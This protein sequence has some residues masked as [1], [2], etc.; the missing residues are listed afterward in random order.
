MLRQGYSG[1]VS[2]AL[3]VRTLWWFV[4]LPLTRSRPQPIRGLSTIQ[5]GMKE[6]ACG[7]ASANQRPP[8]SLGAESAVICYR[9]PYKLRCVSTSGSVLEFLSKQILQAGAVGSTDRLLGHLSS[10][11]RRL[12]LGPS[13]RLS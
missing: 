4:A 8:P 7:R 13:G 12:P 2:I 5:C 10:Q 1:R 9:D 11:G 3:L 6:H